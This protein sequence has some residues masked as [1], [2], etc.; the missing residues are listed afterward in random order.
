[1]SEQNNIEV[2]P[3]EQRRRENEQKCLEQIAKACEGFDNLEVLGALLRYQVD[4]AVRNNASTWAAPMTL[5]GGTVVEGVF[6]VN[7][8]KE[9]EENGRIPE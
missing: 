3:E 4:F 5:P 2:T 8:L 1:M 7:V 6:V 9:A